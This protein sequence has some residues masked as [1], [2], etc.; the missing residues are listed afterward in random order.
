MGASFSLLEKEVTNKERGR[1]ERTLW[2]WPGIR[3]NRNELMIC[4]IHTDRYI[5]K[6]GCVYRCV[7]EYIYVALSTERTYMQ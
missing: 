4:S 2:C 3:G 1:L 5:N 7:R 6:Y